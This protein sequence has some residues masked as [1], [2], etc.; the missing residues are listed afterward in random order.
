MKKSGVL[1]V[2]THLIEFNDFSDLFVIIIQ[3]SNILKLFLYFSKFMLDFFSFGRYNEI[4]KKQGK[5][6]RGKRLWEQSEKEV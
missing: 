4:T 2:M 6:Q 5:R 3:L 1:F